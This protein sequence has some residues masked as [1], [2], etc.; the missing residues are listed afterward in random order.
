MQIAQGAP[1]A[2][3]PAA[4]S[5]VG[6][7]ADSRPRIGRHGNVDGELA[8]KIAFAVENLN[9]AVAAVGDIDVALGVGGDAVR[10]VEL[11]WPLPRSPHDL[12][13]LPFLS[14]LATRELM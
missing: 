4:S 13:Q 12:S 14:T 11:A 5:L 8:Q 1:G 7:I 10:R 3:V 2:N 6:H 9:A